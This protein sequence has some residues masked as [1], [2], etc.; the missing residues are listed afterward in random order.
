M[1]CWE[2]FSYRAESFVKIFDAFGYKTE[3]LEM[4]T[5]FFCKILKT[6]QLMLRIPIL[7]NANK[8]VEGIS[9]PVCISSMFLLFFSDHSFLIGHYVMR[10][11]EVERDWRIIWIPFILA[12]SF[13]FTEKYSSTYFIAV[14]CINMK[15]TTNCSRSYPKQLFIYSLIVHCL[16]FFTVNIIQ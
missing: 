2:E 13:S 11:G 12:R 1:H 10:E 7:W 9:E 14:T 6:D 3:H 8:H 4:L 16:H 5:A 15:T